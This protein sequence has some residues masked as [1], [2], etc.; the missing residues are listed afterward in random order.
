MS[1]ARRILLSLVLF[2]T[3]VLLGACLPGGGNARAPIPQALIP[4]GAPATRLVVV[5][6]GRGDD[7]AALRAS[8]IVTAVQ[9]AWPDA[10]VLLTGLGF[11]YYM[12]GR[13][14]QRLHAEVVSPARQRGYREVWLL[15]ASM[16]GM[17][18]LMY[19]RAYPGE[20]DGLVLLAP[21]LG[22]RLLIDEIRR[23]GL[24]A[25]EAGPV[26]AAV[27]AGNYQRELWRHLQTWQRDPGRTRTVWLGYGAQDRL[28]GAM[29]P[30]AGLLPADHVAV[31]DGGHAWKVWSPLT[32]RLLTAAGPARL[33]PQRSP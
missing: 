14:P 3:T 23:D 20:A 27:D 26:P 17:G 32:Q 33:E 25:W 29:P 2:T 13:A 12:E 8:G 4:A 6:P 7:I 19:D 1:I 9:S 28:A 22:K 5:L 31:V 21:Y 16:G 11:A 30:L 18:S 15:G 10:D 24:G